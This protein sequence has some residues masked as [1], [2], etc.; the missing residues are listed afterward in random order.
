M[1]KVDKTYVNYVNN[2]FITLDMMCISTSTKDYFCSIYF[3]GFAVGII[4][5]TVPD[6]IGRKRTMW[7]L[8]PP[9]ILASSLSVYGSTI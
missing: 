9:Y 3:V 5:F 4:F 2:W 6:A 1:Y 8:L 7:V